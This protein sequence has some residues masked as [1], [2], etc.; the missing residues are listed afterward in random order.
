MKKKLVITVML[1]NIL[2]LVYSQSTLSGTYRYSANADITFT[3][4]TFTGSWNATS[5]ISGTYTVSGSRLTLNITGGPKSP[6]TWVWTIVDAYT[7]RD[8]DGDSWGSISVRPQSNPAPSIDQV[9]STKSTEV[10]VEQAK[11]YYD[12]GLTYLFRDSDY[13][14]AVTAFTEAIKLNPNY[15]SSYN[16]KGFS[17]LMRGLVNNNKDDYDLAIADLNQVIRLDPNYAD[18]FHNRGWAY[19]EKGDYDLAIADLNQ[20]I[21]LSPNDTSNYFVRAEAYGCKGDY[22]L[23]IA[24]YN[25][26]IRL[27]PNYSSAY[28]DRGYAYMQKGN[29]TQA[30]ADVNKALQIDP[31]SDYAQTLSAELRQKGY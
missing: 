27:V 13:D 12:Q 30:R 31:D 29:F 2:A 11:A 10:L 5:P 9:Q 18:G 17:Y 16:W 23:A 28:R 15:A 26:I 4:N 19:K 21:R 24:D 3:G 22:D 20:A 6:N 14:L 25:Q 7:L 1:L 8:H